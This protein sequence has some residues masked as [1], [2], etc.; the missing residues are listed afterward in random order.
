MS[1]IPIDLRKRPPDRENEFDNPIN[2]KLSDI[3]E[4]LRTIAEKYK[5]R[6][7]YVGGHI[8]L[9]ANEPQ[10]VRG[11]NPERRSF[12]MQNFGTGVAY[13]F[14]D[15]TVTSLNG[16]PIFTGG[17]FSLSFNAQEVWAISSTGGTI[18]SWLEE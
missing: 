10:L 2:A 9:V 8:A 16:L 7:D 6:T 15:K 1:H 3:S 13:V 12:V 17:I 14:K 5:T 11:Y 4:L 18:I